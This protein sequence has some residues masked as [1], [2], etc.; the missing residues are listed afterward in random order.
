MVAAAPFRAPTAK[1]MSASW[2][3]RK[4]QVIEENRVL[5]VPHC[6]FYGAVKWLDA[7][8]GSFLML[9]CKGLG[10][11]YDI[12]LSY[13]S[14]V[15][16]PR[17]G[18]IHRSL[19]SDKRLALLALNGQSM[20]RAFTSFWNSLHWS[21]TS[22]VELSAKACLEFGGHAF[23]L[24]SE[25]AVKTVEFTRMVVGG[26]TLRSPLVD[27]DVDD[28][29]SDEFLSVRA[30]AL[31]CARKGIKPFGR[32]NRL[33][34][35][36]AEIVETFLIQGMAATRVA[37]VSLRLHNAL[38]EAT[39]GGAARLYIRMLAANRASMWMC[40]AALHGLLCFIRDEEDVVM[41]RHVLRQGGG[42]D[43]FFADLIDA[44]VVAAHPLSEWHHVVDPNEWLEATL[45][46][47]DD[48]NVIPSDN[49]AES[50]DS[51]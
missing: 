40:G 7:T 1:R 35:D 15:S 4:R 10:A 43:S 38:D 31:E 6:A 23:F 5:L 45:A 50:S 42:D 46:A 16:N 32:D 11:S 21:L 47:F 34:I 51:E 3:S 37:G 27:V 48:E 39:E 33:W 22:D 44:W 18:C 29:L 14:N 24:M 25:R 28:W 41:A 8:D 20:P 12:V 13:L 19:Q 49:D 26:F 36:D 17:F 2:A 30:H 9:A